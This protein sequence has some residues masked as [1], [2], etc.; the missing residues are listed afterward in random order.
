MLR[1]V[2]PWIRPIILAL[3]MGRASLLAC[4]CN[5]IGPACEAAWKADAVFL[6][7]VTHVY[8]LTIFGFPLAWPFPTERRTTF[9][10]KESYRGPTE[11]TIEILTAMGCCACGIEFQWGQ[12]YLVYAYRVPG[13]RAL[14]TS[15]CSRTSRAQDAASDLAYLR[16]LSSSAP[17]AHIYGFV[18]AN[19]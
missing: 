13:T 10:V 5:R 6:G 18:T 9:A 16:S 14:A 7:T 4:S 2:N 8:P 1:R 15:I 19:P 17:P 11:A 3:L 12:D